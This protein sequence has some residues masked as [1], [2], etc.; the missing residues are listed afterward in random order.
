MWVMKREWFNVNFGVH[1]GSILD[2]FLFAVIL[3]K[4]T[5]GVRGG[6]LKE[7]CM[8][9]TWCFLETVTLHL[10]SNLNCINL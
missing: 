2:P 1:Q 5:K 6:L 9:M 7:L 4:I 3:D 10:Q 8:Q